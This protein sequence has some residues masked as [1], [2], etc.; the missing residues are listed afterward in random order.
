M[1]DGTTR[2]KAEKALRQ[3]EEAVEKGSYISSAKVPS[4]SEVADMWLNAKKPNL[5]QSTYEQYRGHVENH[6]RPFSGNMKITRIYL[7]VVEDLIHQDHP[8]HL[9]TLD[10][11]RK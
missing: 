11:R 4:F 1:P 7:E 3:I 9:W 8:G 5:R 2:T 6:L 10:E